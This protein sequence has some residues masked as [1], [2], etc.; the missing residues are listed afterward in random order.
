MENRET[1]IWSV[2]G[3]AESGMVNKSGVSPNNGDSE[4]KGC[5]L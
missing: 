2:S 4:W 5:K 3:P 1:V